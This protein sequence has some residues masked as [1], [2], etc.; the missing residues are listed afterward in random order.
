MGLPWTPLH[1]RCGTSTE[2]SEYGREVW[3]YLLRV[4]LGHTSQTKRPPTSL[5]DLVRAGR[6][7]P[8]NRL[9]TR[10]MAGRDPTSSYRRYSEGFYDSHLMLRLFIWTQI[11][12]WWKGPITML[13]L[14]NNMC[15]K[16][17]QNSPE[18]CPISGTYEQCLNG[19]CPSF[20]P[21]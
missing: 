3:T 13:L 8:C 19:S 12:S 6:E 11:R 16:L 15:K 18:Y 21:G 7:S 20:S 2:W 4:L 17:G 14:S 1:M 5:D 9:S 10:Y